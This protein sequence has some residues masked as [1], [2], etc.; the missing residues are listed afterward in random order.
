MKFNFDTV[1]AFS[2]P[3][4]IIA[5]IGV[6]HNGDM[7]QARKMIA[8]AK[9]AGADAV[10]FQTFAAK[11]LVTKGTPKVRYQETTTDAG[12]THFDMI[13]RLELKR[14]Q[15]LPLMKHCDAI[16]IDF[17]STPYDIDSAAFL[18]NVGVGL[19]KTASADIVDLPLQRFLAQTKKPVIVS[20]GMASFGEVETV[21]NLYRESGNTQIILLHCVSN[22]P[23]SN[24]SLNLRVIQALHDTFQ[25]PVGFSDHSEGRH[26]AIIAVALGARVVEK[27]FTLDKNLPGPD[28]KASST[29]DEFSDLVQSI[30]RA[31]RA[32]GSSI[33]EC[34]EEERQ[35]LQVSRKS[36]VLKKSV[37]K[38]ERITSD[39][40]TMKRPGTGISSMEIPRITDKIAK[41]DMPEDH[42]LRW[43]DIE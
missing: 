13:E 38:G 40:L 6:N 14:D 43:S 19:F 21:V 35:M 24:D 42:L 15:H 11:A 17:M 32:L 27:H 16:G 28:H 5:E 10:K 20:T 23:C 8:A 18:D 3:C 41:R 25:I 1:A 34:Q 39:H 22:Y 7:K 9:D 12:E 37:R 29:P 36:V 30:R 31:E 33:K 2:S 26:A 4:Y